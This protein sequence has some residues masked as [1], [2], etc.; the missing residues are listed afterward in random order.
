MSMLVV[1]QIAQ[2]VSQ[3]VINYSL[4]TSPKESP[5]SD[6]ALFVSTDEDIVATILRACEV[7]ESGLVSLIALD[8]AVALPKILL[9]HA[10]ELSHVPLVVHIE[11]KR[12]LSSVF[13]LHTAFPCLL[14]SVTP[15]EAH[16]NSIIATHLA[17]SL[18]VTVIHIYFQDGLGDAFSVDRNI[19]LEENS[20]L[21][22]LSGEMRNNNLSATECDVET[23]WRAYQDMTSRLSRF[24]SRPL[25]P[26]SSQH[27]EQ[28]SDVHTVIFII[29]HHCISEITLAG[30][31]IIHPN[32]IAPLSSSYILETV[33][34]HASRVFI[35]EQLQ[36]WPMKWTPFHLEVTRALQQ[37]NPTPLIRE[38]ILGYDKTSITDSD[39]E[40]LLNSPKE[41]IQLGTF[42]TSDPP[43]IP[44]IPKHESSYF[45]VLRNL[46]D[47]R[48][49]HS[50][51]PDLVAAHGR[52]VTTPEF[53]LGRVR[54]QL[55]ERARLVKI[56]ESL[57]HDSSADNNLHS[58]LSKW[59]LHRDDVLLSHTFGD[60]I[61]QGL[62]HDIHNPALR[63]LFTL[64]HRFSLPSHWIVVSS[65]SYDLGSSGL[66]HILSSGLRVNILI[67]HTT[68]YSLRQ[69]NNHRQHDI[70]LY[71][72]NYGSAYVASIAMYSSYAQTMQALAE[73]DRFNGPSV[74]LG[75]LPYLSDQ[76]SAVDVLK[77]TK[78]AVDA[79]YW[80]LYRWNPSK[81]SEGGEPFSL[82]SDS[83]KNHL[84]QFL[85]RQ[86]HLSQL[87]RSKPT[88]ATEIAGSLGQSLREARRSKAQEEYNRLLHTV[89]APPMRILYASDGGEAEKLAKRLAT[90]GRIRGLDVSVA[91]LDSMS[92]DALRCQDG[93]VVF[94]TS[95][96]GQGE[97]P[98]NGRKFF[99]S[100]NSVV[101]LGKDKEIL[102]SGLRYLV[103]GL[104]DSHY[105]PRAED[106]HYYNRPSKELDSK[107]I[108][109]GAQRLLELH[110]GDA[111]DADGP[112]TQY[113]V[114]E[115]QVWKLFGVDSVEVSGKES[116]PITL[117]HIKAASNHLRG[118]IAEGI[119]DT[120]TGGLAPSD[121]PLTK[122][123]GIW[124]QD[125]RDIRE[126]RQ[127]QG[128]EPAYN[129]MVRARMPGGSCTPEQWLRL[130]RLTDEYGNGTMK[131]TT[132]QTLQ[133]HGI[134]KKYLKRS[135]QDINKALL[136]T[137]E[138]GG[139]VNSNIV[140]SSIPTMSEIH[141]Q[142]H[143][144]CMDISERLMPRTTAY[145]EIWL[146]QKMVAGHAVKDFE[147]IYSEWYLPRKF[148]IAIAVPPTNDVDVYTNDLG[149]IA[150]VDDDG[151]NVIGYNVLVGGGMGTTLGN[152]KTYPRVASL[153]GF[154]TPDQAVDVA[155][156]VTLVQRDYGDRVDRKTA[157]LKYTV[158]R[159]GLDKFKAE[160]ER[161]LGFPLQ[162]SRPYSFTQNLDQYGW[163]KGQNGRHYFTTFIENGRIQDTQKTRLKTGL[164]EIA[165]IH[166]GTFRLTTNQHLVV[167]EIEEDNLSNIKNILATY[168]IDI[169][170]LS[171]LRLSSSACVAFPTCGLAMAESERY[172]PIL[173]DKIE[174]ICEEN[175][176]RNDS[177]VMRMTGCPAGCTRPNVAEIGFVGKA[178]GAYVMLLGGGAYGQRL[179][180]V[181]RESVTEPEILAILKP[182]IKHYALDRHEGERFGDFVIRKGFVP[183]VTS[184]QEYWK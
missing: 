10:G 94:I 124:Q 21:D 92:L 140:C 25:Q 63:E 62:G 178:P 4:Q 19:M 31:Q 23:L 137:L 46:F 97:P 170:G 27:S 60:E 146:D 102:L 74:V 87:V 167:S 37:R 182:M 61:I 30:V 117:E 104:G 121:P 112:E 149:Y 57:I 135:I 156:K 85:D 165:K 79:G 176:L 133:F 5:S 130:D 43:T 73:A 80:P 6:N 41:R 136:D 181:Y 15:S 96:A 64:K 163:V 29:G 47:V 132:R 88:L 28:A 89:D 107:L 95:T 115:A 9:P 164:R 153:I 183:A 76:T 148:K 174:T 131:I 20:I 93:H 48:F 16:D 51:S 56:V 86:N 72:M 99:K 49:E 55:E 142:V 154:C 157:R 91:T 143:S 151:K 77:E 128:L 110:L 119:S 35:L 26:F 3:T 2:L 166:K 103:F 158:D 22:Y 52:L 122:Y 45:G 90:R 105:W 83:I 1:S 173:I 54:G 59:H 109:L 33:S 162:E 11:V 18:R 12:N 155:E 184:S 144:F 152:Q 36:D 78:L 42:T 67:I 71:A 14:L 161:R 127:A 123:H 50:N 84:A 81:D 17:R 180:K 150:I 58:L 66:H 138:V 108:L 126:E 53:A 69:S 68:P 179:A 177:I 118:T 40:E 8:C 113:K 38:A 111:R 145:H 32:I 44:L 98:Q 171:G 169:Q 7:A 100:L 82:D 13:L 168:N 172:L 139:D 101:S 34:P 147:P 120:T 159:M 75:Y 175:G 116:E 129:F 160:V 141:A 24:T 65:W 39:L 125:D 134:L 70:G 106:A 114:W